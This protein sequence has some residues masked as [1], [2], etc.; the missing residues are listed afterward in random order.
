MNFLKNGLSLDEFKVSI[1]AIV[2]VTIAGF[3]LYQYIQT[4][5]ITNNVSDIIKTCVYVIGGVNGV[6]GLAKVMDNIK[7]N[8][9]KTKIKD[10]ENPKTFG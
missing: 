5:D 3:A 2:F 8:K 7:S 9:E 6:N 4:G 10:E 1:L